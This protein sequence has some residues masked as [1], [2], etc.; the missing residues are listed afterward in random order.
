MTGKM[1]QLLGDCL[2][3]GGLVAYTGC[4]A[5]KDRVSLMKKWREIIERHQ[6]KISPEFVMTEMLCSVVDVQK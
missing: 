5:T 4:L 6:V 3:A 2:L 1:D